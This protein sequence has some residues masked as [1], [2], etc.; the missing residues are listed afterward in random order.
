MYL[1]VTS[2][3]TGPAKIHDVV[4]KRIKSVMGVDEKDNDNDMLV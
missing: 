1:P 4:T 2:P 3:K